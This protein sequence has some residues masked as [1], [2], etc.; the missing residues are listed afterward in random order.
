MAEAR[1]LLLDTCAVIWLFN[2]SP[3][4][5]PSRQ[6]IAEAAIAG[7]LFVSPFSGWEIATLVRKGKIAL[8]MSPQQWFRNVAENEAVTLAPLDYPLLIDSC[9]LP[10]EPPNDPADRIMVATA[11]AM[12]LTIVTRDRPILDYAQQG[13]VHGLEC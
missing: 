2:R 5:G 9:A 11:R 12:A 4:S 8:T 13:H 1:P 7:R 10:S 3:M 6:A